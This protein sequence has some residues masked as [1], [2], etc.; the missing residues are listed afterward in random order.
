MPEARKVFQTLMPDVA[1]W[2]SANKERHSGFYA[3]NASLDHV[4]P[5]RRGG[6]NELDN[7]VTA[8]WP[9]QFGRSN[10]LLSEVEILAPFTRPPL[11]D[12]WDGLKRVLSIK[13]KR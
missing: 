8:C 4:L 13:H 2:G 10:W 6:S 7:V 11:V 12:R 1:R 3:L 9:C 5:H